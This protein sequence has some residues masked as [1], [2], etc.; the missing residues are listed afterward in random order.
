MS[1]CTVWQLSNRIA[2]DFKCLQL[3]VELVE[4][5]KGDNA[6]QCKTYYIWYNLRD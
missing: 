4:Q 5:L 2:Y 3:K 1:I 6:K